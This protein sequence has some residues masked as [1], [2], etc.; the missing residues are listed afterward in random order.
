MSVSSLLSVGLQKIPDSKVWILDSKGWILDSKG[1]IPNS[2]SQ[3][4]V[5]FRILYSLTCG[6]TALSGFYD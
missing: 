1:W 2:K 3:E 5:E 4:Y 6:E